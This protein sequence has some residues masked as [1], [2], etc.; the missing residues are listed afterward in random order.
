MAKRP[1]DHHQLPLAG[2]EMGDGRARVEID[3][4]LL[5]ELPGAAAKLALADPPAPRAANLPNENV[6]GHAQRFDDADFLRHVADPLPLGVV[7]R[8]QIDGLAI[9]ANRPP[10]FAGGINAVENLHQSRFAGP[11]RSDEAMNLPAADL[12]RDILQRADRPKVFGDA[13]DFDRVVVHGR[14]RAGA[15]SLAAPKPP[16]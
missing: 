4:P 10:I 13:G 6:L 14:L 1:S 5:Q 15:G 11:V 16:G 3:M 9:D 8:A 7:R 12:Q 2:R